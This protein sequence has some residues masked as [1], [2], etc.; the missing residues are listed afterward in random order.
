MDRVFTKT[1]VHEE[2]NETGFRV[3]VGGDEK[4]VCVDLWVSKRVVFIEKTNFWLREDLEGGVRS[5][6]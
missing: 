1:E 4:G 5:I 2:V 6:V 3:V